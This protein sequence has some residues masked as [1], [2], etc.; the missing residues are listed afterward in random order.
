MWLD[1]N[2]IGFE[3][4]VCDLL[5]KSIITGEVVTIAI[6][7][8]DNIII[9]SVFK[10]L[11]YLLTEAKWLLPSI[12]AFGGTKLTDLIPNHLIPSPATQWIKIGSLL[13]AGCVSYDHSG[14]SNAQILMDCLTYFIKTIQ[15]GKAEFAAEMFFETLTISV[16]ITRDF[17]AIIK[18]LGSFR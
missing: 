17:V 15:N 18:S 5:H 6:T 9:H 7:S 2:G 1:L 3:N 14:Q 12:G 10:Y 11:K 16:L 13:L 8:S 4:R